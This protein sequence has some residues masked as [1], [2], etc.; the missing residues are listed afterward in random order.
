MVITVKRRIHSCLGALPLVLAASAVALGL[1]SCKHDSDMSGG[2]AGMNGSSGGNGPSGSG[3]TMNSGGF[4]AFG[5]MGTMGVE[6]DVPSALPPLPKVANVKAVAVDDNVDI[7]FDPVDG[8]RDYRVYVLP[9]DADVSADGNGV[10][11]V[12]NALYRCAGDRQAVATLMDGGPSIPGLS[13]RSQVDNQSVSD[14]MRTLPEATLGHVY[15]SPGAGRVAVHAMGDPAQ[16]ADVECDNGQ[17]ISRWQSSRA[18]KYVLDAEYQTLLGKRWRDD[19]IAFYAPEAAGGN[20]RGILTML[21][22]EDARLY[23]AEGPEATKRAKGEPAFNVLTAPEAGTLPLLRAFYK[24]TCGKSHDELAV[25]NARFERIRKQGDL[26]PTWNLHWAGLTGETILVVEALAE[27]CPYQGFLAPTAQNPRAMYPA[28][29]TL[30]QLRAMSPTGEV[31]INGQHAATNKPRPVAR[32]FV[33]ISPGPKPDMD[34]FEGFNKPDALGPMT[35]T[36]CGEPAPANCWQQFRRL[37]PSMDINF[38]YVENDRWAL[39]P[40]LGEL[41]VTYGDVG[42]DVNGKFRL[43]PKTKATMA[44]DKFLHA[45]MTVD[46]FTTGRRY[47]QILISDQESPVQWN[48]TKGYGLIVQSF[49]GWPYLYHVELCD[50]RLWD[51][52]MQCPA[53]DMYHI[54]DPADPMKTANL[55]PNDEPGEHMG[56]DRGTRWDVFA[57]TKRVYLYLDGAPYGCADLPAGKVTAGPA[58]VTFGDVLYHSGVDATFTYTKNALQLSTRRHFDNLGFKSNVDAPGWDESRM[59]CVRDMKLP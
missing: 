43:T 29:F 18:K 27:G 50:H 42:A 3:G 30:E 45:T 12:K 52:N 51:V 13:I 31:Y 48:M 17:R 57:S 21:G 10:V 53:F 41:W 5:G 22:Q 56:L 33:K 26:L 2:G 36:P 11:T 14:Y 34:W 38:M 7:T 44:A 15:T 49:S 20:T 16:N 37:T 24:S 39:A 25:G 54:K 47:P 58:T 55:A 28:W 59:P 46:M 32:T 6:N 40:M 19:G 1:V 23:F 4:G 8:A 9:S 35:D